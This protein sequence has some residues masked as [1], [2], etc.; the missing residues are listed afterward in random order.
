MAHITAIA[1]I[2]SLDRLEPDNSH[3]VVVER[4]QW[5]TRSETWVKATVRNSTS[6]VVNTRP[7]IA[8]FVAAIVG[9]IDRER[10]Y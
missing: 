8:F 2:M 5:L 9:L 1:H 10:K 3:I 4:H 6:L 7:N